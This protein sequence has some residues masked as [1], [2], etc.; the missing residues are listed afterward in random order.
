MICLKL[1]VDTRRG[2]DEG[3]PPLL[4][5]LRDE[6]VQASVYFT[7]GPDESGKAVRRVFT[8]P[9]FLKKMLRTNAAKMYG[10]R[11]MLYGTLLPAPPIG[12]ARGDLLKRTEQ[13][14]HEVGLHAWNHVQWQDCLDSM[15][16]NQ[17]EAE[18][19]RA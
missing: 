8:K 9:G 10:W 1:D 13:E 5:L 4:S 17:I 6:G 2:L 7:M 16:E 19:S 3:L 12:G 15:K 14:G 11:T 18:L